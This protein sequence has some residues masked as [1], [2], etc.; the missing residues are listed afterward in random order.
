MPVAVIGAGWAG[1]VAAVELMNRGRQVL[2][3]EA[4]RQVGGRARRLDLMHQGQS[5]ALDNGQHILIGAYRDTLRV[6]RGLG[7]QPEQLLKRLPLTL[8]FADGRGLSLPRWRHKTPAG[9]AA[10]VGILGAQGWTLSDKFKL[11]RWALGWRLRGF[12]C[13][14]ERSVLELCEDLPKALLDALIAPLCVS[15]LNTPI[16]RASGSVF[17]RVLQDALMS[18]P[19]GSDLLLP[20][21][22]LGS[23]LPHAAVKKLRDQGQSVRLGAR[24][25]TL[26]PDASGWQLEVQQ[27]GQTAVE[28]AEAV[29]LACPS[30]EAARLVSTLPQAQAWQQQALALQHEAITTVYAH[31]QGSR[32]PQPMLALEASASAPAQFVFDRGQLGGPAGLLAFVVSASQG[33]RQDL[34]QRVLSQAE[35]ELGLRQLTLVQTVVER[36]ATFACTPGLQRPGLQVV[37]GD[38]S[39]L[40]CGDYIDGP[41][42]ATLE[43]AVRSG[44]SAAG[45]LA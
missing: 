36:R 28:V 9:L 17:L 13:A 15:A 39:L 40:A 42:P 14:A 21:C 18:S 22:D 37:A 23:L 7:L 5:L 29:V 6:M 19:D 1:C 10:G 25:L 45:G 35:R 34:E 33:D 30:G 24:A 8:R 31:S 16:E 43:G 11:L 2:L 4:A 41:Y 27:D 26:R 3:V 20:L 38:A 32:L 12:E 44:L